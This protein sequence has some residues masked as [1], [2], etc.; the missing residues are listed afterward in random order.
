MLIET[1][2]FQGPEFYR[3]LGFEQIAVV[4]NN[5]AGHQH[6]V[7]RKKLEQPL[8]LSIEP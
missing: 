1:H 5:P 8:A 6:L 3:K 4:E 7:L 2:S